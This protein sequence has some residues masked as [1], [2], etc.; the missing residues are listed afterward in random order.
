MV[1]DL[2]SRGIDYEGATPT[3]KA[4]WIAWWAE[5]RKPEIEAA[6]RMLVG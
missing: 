3:M 1:M 6:R 5:V 2:L 4:R